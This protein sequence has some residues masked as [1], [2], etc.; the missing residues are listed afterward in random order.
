MGADCYTRYA[1][2][3]LLLSPVFYHGMTNLDKN[4]IAE[5]K[6]SLEE[7]TIIWEEK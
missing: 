3:G 4:A 6:D 5:T 2:Y 1:Q 7:G